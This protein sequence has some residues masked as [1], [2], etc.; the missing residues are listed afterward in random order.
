VVPAARRDAGVR[1]E[2][3]TPAGNLSELV[4]HHSHGAR[5]RAMVRYLAASD[6]VTTP[7]WSTL[8]IDTALALRTAASRLADEFI[9]TFGTETIE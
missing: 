2:V 1:V 6:G 3:V 4:S 5:W 8:S 7:T 9:G